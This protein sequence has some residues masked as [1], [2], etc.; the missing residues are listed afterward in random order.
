MKDLELVNRCIQRDPLAWNEFIRRYSPL[1][2]WAIENRLKKWDYFYQPEDIEE[3]HQ[4]VFFSL[5]KKNKLEQI[6][7]QQKIS[8]WLIIISGNEAIDYFRYQKSQTPPNAIS[9]F[10]EIIEK[11]KVTTIKDL[12]PSKDLNPYAK[13]ELTEVEKILDEEI[14]KLPPKEKIIVRLNILYN[15]KYREIAEILNMPVGSVSTALKNIKVK[16][17]KQLRGKI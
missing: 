13:T 16:L 17:K 10:E 1:V 7:E 15:K 14:D 12:L 5:W 9:I 6:R 3:I 4:N 8:G 11:D 2:Y